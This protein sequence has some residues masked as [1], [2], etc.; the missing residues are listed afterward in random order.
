M[1]DQ[2]KFSMLCQ[3]TRLKISS[4]ILYPNEWTNIRAPQ[5]FLSLCHFMFT[6][7]EEKSC[8]LLLLFGSLDLPELLLAHR[9][10]CYYTNCTAVAASPT[11]MHGEARGE[12]PVRVPQRPNPMGQLAKFLPYSAVLRAAGE[13]HSKA[14]RELIESNKPNQ[15]PSKPA[16]FHPVEEPRRFWVVGSAPSCS[17][18]H[19]TFGELPFCRILSAVS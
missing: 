9:H 6:L 10:S 16:C 15:T 5:L 19:A 11:Q 7:R 2:Y 4:I 14:L 13:S 17:P 12:Q 1:R 8:I 18:Y 3:Q